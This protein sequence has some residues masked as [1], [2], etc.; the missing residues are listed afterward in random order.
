MP[1]NSGVDILNIKAD[2]ELGLGSDNAI[3]IPAVALEQVNKANQD[4][5]AY[6]LQKQTMRYEQQLKQRDN[7]IKGL[8]EGEISTGAILPEDR[9]AYNKAEQKVREKFLAVTSEEPDAKGQNVKLADYHD[10]KQEL[11]DLS[12]MLQSRYVEVGKKR[13]QRA[14]TNIKSEQNALDADISTTLAA[15]KMEPVRPF[16]KPFTTD[17]EKIYAEG[18]KGAW[19]DDEG[20]PVNDEATTTKVTTNAKGTT[21]QKTT[22]PVKVGKD[23]K[24]I[25]LTGDVGKDGKLPEVTTTPTKRLSDAKIYKNIE[26]KYNNDEEFR[27]HVEG[28]Y[29]MLQGTSDPKLLNHLLLADT[30]LAQKDQE[31]GIPSIKYR[32]PGNRIGPPDPSNPNDP[33]G[34]VEDT[35]HYPSQINY[36]MVGNK[37]VI[38]E[39]AVSL[40]A[41]LTA[42]F[43]DTPNY[44]VKGQKSINP[45]AVKLNQDSRKIDL[46]ADKIKADLL[47]DKNATAL[48][49]AEFGLDKKYKNWQMNKPKNESSAASAAAYAQAFMSKLPTIT[50]ANGNVDLSK[51]S[52]E[53]LK[54]LGTGAREN[55]SFTLSPL[56]VSKGAKLS[57]KDGQ[58]S[59]L[60]PIRNDKKEITGYEQKP[61]SNIDIK[62]IAGNRLMEE[63]A[64]STGKE[65]IE[66][67]SLIP[68]YNE[69]QSGSTQ[70]GGKLTFP[71]G[72]TVDIKSSGL[73]D[74]EIKAAIKAGAKKQ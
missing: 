24:N 5:R 15:P 74:A 16:Q 47:K 50:D 48:K 42:A 38:E 37:A 39:T 13:A 17:P 52:D 61:G 66:W 40:A 23:G 46:E 44:V 56:D 58:L 3:P 14:N 32:D 1:R 65:A 63:V 59:V 19:V 54:Y 35:G 30:R 53:E 49:W 25:P 67:N 51:L 6:D 64:S 27:Q 68:L 2:P 12:T 9:D 70:T 45:E 60:T 69:S 62:K 18:L 10:A 72:S 73:T 55:N 4:F 7:L 36:R 29:E 33:V 31:N 22:A 26:S 11:Q 71:D 41:K 43:A 20:N 8:H 34:K 21:I 57:F 28:M